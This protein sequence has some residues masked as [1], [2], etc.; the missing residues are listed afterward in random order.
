MI[1]QDNVDGTVLEQMGNVLNFSLVICD[2]GKVQELYDTR[3]KKAN[4][5]KNM[6]QH[7]FLR[8]GGGVSEIQ[9]LIY[10]QNNVNPF[11]ICSN[12]IQLSTVFVCYN[13]YRKYKNL[14]SA[15]DF[16]LVILCIIHRS[17]KDGGISILPECIAV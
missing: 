3:D 13:F 10:Q 8:G 11:E 14:I 12:W 17:K 1:V 5:T 15:S 16:I 6:A 4:K 9:C 2:Y 7:V